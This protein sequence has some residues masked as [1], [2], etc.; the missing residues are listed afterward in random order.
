MTLHNGITDDIRS[1]YTLGLRNGRYG[2]P[3]TSMMLDV[4]YFAPPGAQITRTEPAVGEVAEWERSGVEK[5]STAVSKTVF[6]PKGETVTV[7]YTVQ[8]P[9]GELGPLHLRHTQTANPTS[10]TIDASCD[11]LFPTS[12][13]EG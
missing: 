1:R 8:L 3:D 6:V 10:V 5:G 4:L 9:E 2:I 12:D 11:A 13:A 7:S